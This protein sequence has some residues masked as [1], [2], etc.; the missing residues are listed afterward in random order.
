M[1]SSFH[2]TRLFFPPGNKY[3]Y[4]RK[5]ICDI[6]QKIEH[7]CISITNT[8]CWKVV[9]CI[10]LQT[11]VTVESSLI[12]VKKKKDEEPENSIALSNMRML[13]IQRLLRMVKHHKSYWNKKKKLKFPTP[14]QRIM[15]MPVSFHNNATSFCKYILHQHLH[16]SAGG[17]K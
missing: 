17:K 3:K 6:W 10:H 8:N 5:V 2:F 14:I 4:H 1:L 12:K 7:S 15:P 16:Y 13:F 9:L 11:P